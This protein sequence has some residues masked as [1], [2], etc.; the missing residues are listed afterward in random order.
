MLE[1]RSKH[2]EQGQ[3]KYV[4]PLASYS[5]TT[6]D[7]IVRPDATAGAMTITLPPVG[8][9]KGR[10][11][12]IFAYYA[13]N[14]NT[15]TIRPFTSTGFAGGDAEGWAGN[16]VLNEMG[17][18]ATFYSDGRKWHYGDKHFTSSLAAGNVNLDEVH[19]TVN[20]AGT[21]NIDA[22]KCTLEIGAVVGAQ[23]GA[24]MAKLD[25]DVS[26]ARTTGL[27]YAVGAEVILPN[28]VGVV[29]GHYTCVDHELS[30][31]DVM[32]ITGS[33]RVSYMRFAAWGTQTAIDDSAD[34]FHL[35][36][37][38]GVDHLLSVNAQ[39]LRV[40]IVDLPTTI[41][42]RFVVLSTEQNILRHV[43]TVTTGNFGMHITGAIDD[44]IS[45]GA[46]AYFQANVSGTPPGIVMG[47]GIW[48]NIN[49]APVSGVIRNLDIGIYSGADLAGADVFNVYM[50]IISAG[51]AS[52]LTYQFGFNH[53]GDAIDG[54]LWASNPGSIAMDVADPT[55]GGGAADAR[56]KMRVGGNT[57]YLAV[58]NA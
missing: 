31:G 57:Y 11:Y 55:G 2:H 20:T 46:A 6:R 35:S 1:S 48:T 7:Y 5:M 44:G 3:D 12:S 47:T 4:V 24:F 8:E 41:K 9:C 51:G 23:A 34:F 36:A 25:F 43:S 18:G 10:F 52:N 42:E 13:T 58:Y 28:L 26:T 14:T 30:A 32:T 40:E 16:L 19:L 27:G 54:L 37:T 49:E 39:T 45:E 17:R 21:Q 15:I 38:G 53:N 50:S 22:C 56:I 29:S 33:T